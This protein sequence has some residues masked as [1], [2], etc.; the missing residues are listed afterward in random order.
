[1]WSMQISFDA[2][3]NISIDIDKYVP[4]VDLRN[5]FGHGID[6]GRNAVTGLFGRASDT[7]YHEVAKA[8]GV[9]DRPCP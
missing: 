3:G 6:V 8:I 5:I 4:G 9:N 7:N 1:M 2:N